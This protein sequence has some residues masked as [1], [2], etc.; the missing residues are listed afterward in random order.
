MKGLRRAWLFAAAGLVACQ[1]QVE[2]PDLSGL[3]GDSGA[4]SDLGVD[5]PGTL[6]L[7][8]GDP[9]ANRDPGAEA[10]P[11]DRLEDLAR[12]AV[13][14]IGTDP[15]ADLP[16]EPQI[17]NAPCRTEAG[18][19]SGICMEG[20][21]RCTETW[22]CE[23]G[24]WCDGGSTLV[25]GTGQCLPTRGLAAGC[26]FHDQC[27]TGACDPTGYCAWCASGGTGCDPN[28]VCCFGECREGCLG[29]AVAP[30]PAPVYTPCATGCYDAE[31]EFCGP[32]GA[33]PKRPNGSDCQFND[34]WCQSGVCFTEDLR[35]S[36]CADC[37][38]DDDCKALHGGGVCIGGYCAI[39]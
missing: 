6:D 10:V 21:C 8:I 17:G 3:L 4:R 14:D 25:R 38:T 29:C 37:R 24:M 34:A 13:E 27:Q 15:A 2:A 32:N 19:I 23:A 20:W 22:H 26:Q 30:P 11:E 28:K 35:V 36:A 7:P 18:C 12:D 39:P 16:E 9:D 31:K 5:V 1:V 33:E